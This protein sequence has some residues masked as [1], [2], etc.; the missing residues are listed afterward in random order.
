MVSSGVI[1]WDYSSKRGA[2]AEEN[3]THPRRGV[4]DHVLNFS[5]GFARRL[6]QFFRGETLRLCL[7]RD[8]P[9]DAVSK[10]R[11]PLGHCS[12]DLARSRLQVSAG[13]TQKISFDRRRRERGG[14]R[15][16]DA[17]P[18]AP[19]TNGWRC[20]RSAMF[21]C[22]AAKARVF[23]TPMEVVSATPLFAPTLLSASP[24]PELSKDLLPLKS[25]T[26]PIPINAAG[27]GWDRMGHSHCA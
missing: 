13:L 12:R 2:Q 15:G 4:C 7:L 16:A 6:L 5:A 9:G 1:S 10:I 18:I 3:R 25:Q 22:A 11:H 17:E 20:M 14:H 21:D 24:P 8:R 23:D 27:S 26:S 19:R